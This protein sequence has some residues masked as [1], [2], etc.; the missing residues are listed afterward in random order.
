MKQAAWFSRRVVDPTNSVCWFAMDALWLAQ[1]EW[2]AY[3]A[4][5]LTL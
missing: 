2:P 5:G 1:L 3:L 4:S